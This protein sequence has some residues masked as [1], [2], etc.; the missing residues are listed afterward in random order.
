MRRLQ[1]IGRK[2]QV[3]NPQ[4]QQPLVYSSGHLLGLPSELLVLVVGKLDTH[5]MITLSLTCTTLNDLIRKEFLFKEVRL[6]SRSNIERFNRLL[7]KSGNRIIPIIT[8]L[9]LTSPA[10]RMDS[11]DVSMGTI[12]VNYGSRNNAIERDYVDCLMDMS[13][14]P[15]L[16]E[17]IILDIPPRFEFPSWTALCKRLEAKDRKWYGSAREIVPKFSVKR[18]DLS[19]ASG[20]SIPLRSNL[21]WTFGQFIEL[22]LSNMIID[23]QSLQSTKYLYDANSEDFVRDDAIKDNYASACQVLV[24][25]GCSVQPGALKRLPKY[26]CQ[27][28]RLELYGIKNLSDLTVVT[29]FHSADTILL[30]FGSRVFQN[31][32][33]KYS[34]SFDGFFALLCNFPWLKKLELINVDFLNMANVPREPTNSLDFSSY[35]VCLFWF[36]TRLSQLSELSI[37]LTSNNSNLIRDAEDRDWRQLLNPFNGEACKVSVYTSKGMLLHK[38]I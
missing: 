19:S 10:L 6:D 25:S 4:R 8:R 38:K 14:L 29:S 1:F 20:W 26:F 22:R 12:G 34:G 11:M 36:F 15:N 16:Q 18:L 2:R 35:K 5:S 37:V 24:L 27:V 9:V 32:L 23:S 28:K 3:Q 31:F 13:F 33:H 30:D 7:R 17:L 21:L